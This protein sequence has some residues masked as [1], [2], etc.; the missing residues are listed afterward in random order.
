MTAVAMD[1]LA[2]IRRHGGDV[3]VIAPDC[4]KVRAP[5]DLLP[6][7]VRQVRAVKPELIAALSAIASSSELAD[8]AKAVPATDVHRWQRRFTAK[9]F[10]WLAG[11]RDWEG[12]KRLAWGD[13]QNEWHVKHGRRWPTWQC[14]GCDAPIGRLRALDLPDGNRVHF[15]PIDCLVMFGKRWRGAAIAALIELG[16]EPPS[17]NY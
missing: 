17:E 2:S 4:L 12:A 5:M 8:P 3:K 7:F 1:V 9:T 11:N 16:L 10:Q 15:E 13:L 6:D 14:A